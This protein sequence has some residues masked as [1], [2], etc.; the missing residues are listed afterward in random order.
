MLEKSGTIV[1]TDED[2]KELKDGKVSK[3]VE[4]NWGLSVEQLKEVV[5]NNE[6]K[7]LNKSID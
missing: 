5:K 4:D 3:R 6:Y 1:L 2:L 7:P